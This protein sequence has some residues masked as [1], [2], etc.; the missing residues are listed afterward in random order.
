MLS[1]HR[2]LSLRYLRQRS[3]RALLIVASIALGVATLV[4]TR[5]LSNS[6]RQAAKQSINP[7]AGTADLI[8]SNGETGVP[9]SLAETLSDA[10]IPGLRTV[11]PIVLTRAAVREL[12]GRSVWLLG[13]PRDVAQATEDNV[14]GIEAT[15]KRDP[16]FAMLSYWAQCHIPFAHPPIPVLI[17]AATWHTSD[18]GRTW[19]RG[20]A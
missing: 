8:I 19:H 4:A 14:L 1:L 16:R 12:D 2:T 6:M 7:L 3:T 15:F 5:T 11:T 17:G 20:Q 10:R 13:V 18:G 9:R